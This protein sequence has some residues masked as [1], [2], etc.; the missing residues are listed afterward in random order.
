MNK[1]LNEYPRPQFK[2]NSFLNLNGQWKLQIK[3]KYNGEITVPYPP[4]STLSGVEIEIGKKDILEYTKVFDFTKIKEKQ[5]LHIGACDQFAEVF[6]NGE[7]LGKHEGGYI[8]FSFDVTKFIKNGKNTLKILACDPLDLDLPYGKQRNKRGGMWYTK[9]SGIWQT[10]WIE[11]VCEN[12]LTS[13]KLT[14]DLNGVLI[15]IDGGENAKT[16]IFGDKEYTFENSFYLKV[17]KPKHWTPNTPHLYDFKIKSGEDEIESYFALREIKIENGKI[18]LN[19]KEIFLNAVLD[20]GYFQNGIFTPS[21]YKVFENDILTM[22]SCGFNTLRKHIKLECENFYY[23]CD[24]LGMLVM[25]DFINSGKYSFVLDTAIATLGLKKGISHKA[26]KRRERAFEE[27]S[28]QIM[29]RLHNHPSVVYYTI[30]NEGWGQFRADYYY[31]FFKEKDSTRIFDTASGWFKTK[32]SDVE[33]EHIYFKKLT[34]KKSKKPIILSEFGG[35]SYKDKNHA[36]NLKNTYG[37]RFFEKR[38]DFENAIIS[39]YEN[40]VIPLKSQGLCGS[41]LTQLSDV[42]DETNGLLTYDREVLKIDPQKLK[43]TLDKLI[44]DVVE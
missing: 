40:E 33:S 3:N 22:K 35:Y 31:N 17:K 14:P 34:L 26:S 13:L 24:K 6:L 10:V 21:S 43:Q 36:F 41:V 29:N 9:I 8:N 23:L 12:H 37:Y 16:L 42:E 15:E 2:R 32:K 1:I 7:F 27:T 44:C 30:F 19:G 38:E 4:E 25:Q 5:I 20:Q 28:I 39:L 11:E 18:K